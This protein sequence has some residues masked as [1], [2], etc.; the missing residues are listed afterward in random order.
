MTSIVKKYNLLI[1]CP[2]DIEEKFFDI[3]LKSVNMINNT[4][5]ETNDFF[6]I[7]K[8]WSFSAYPE[9]GA[10]PQTILNKQFVE[11]CDCAIAMFWSRFGTPTNGYGSGTEEEIGIMLDNKKQVFMY[12]F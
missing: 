11:D 10:E 8:H 12:F 7:P 2:S 6:I 9:S 4:L 5:G 1:S 3:I